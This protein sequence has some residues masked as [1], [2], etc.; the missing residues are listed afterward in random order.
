MRSM[1]AINL[2]DAIGYFGDMCRKNKLA[3]AHNFYPCACSGINSLEGVLENFRRQSAFFAV[4]DTNDG[5]TERRSG[6]FFK[7][8]TFTVFIMKRYPL[9]NMEE[10][11]FA[12]DICRQ[13]AR[14]VH[15]RMLLDREDLSNNLIYLNTDNVYSRELG[16][17]FINGCTGLYFMIDVSEPIDLSFNADEWEN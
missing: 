14:Q 13:L 1:D 17:Y 12:L 7:K 9:N 11:Q 16:E 2:F 10:R 4:D 8:R 15:S 6:G 5:V 3:R